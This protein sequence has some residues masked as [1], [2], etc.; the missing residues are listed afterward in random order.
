MALPY[1]SKYLMPH[2]GTPETGTSTLNRRQ[3]LKTLAL[4][5]IGS[6]LPT[7]ADGLNGTAINHISYQ[8]ADYKKTRDFYIDLLGF[9][10][11]DEDDKQ[12]Y[13]W[14]GDAII[15]AKNSPP[16]TA[17]RMDHFGFTLT[18]YDLTGVQGVLKQRGLAVMMSQ[19]DPHDPDG[20]YKTV[21]TRDP[22]NYTVQLCAK[23]AEVKPAPVPSH[24]PLKAAGIS[25]FSY[26]CSDYKKTVSFYADLFNLKI[27]NDDG[28]RAYVWLGDSFV[29]IRNNPNPAP[30]PVID[31]YAWTLADWNMD[32]VTTILKARNLPITPDPS[33][34]SLMTKDLNGYPL[35]LCSKDRYPKP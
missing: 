31:Y 26:L 10:V 27:S 7:R 24:A 25:H 11:S 14:A 18:P 21:F 5:A 9:Q 1:A 16:T 29:L 30:R 22:N 34:K 32:K 17:P 28:S 13:L 8:S 20:P 23:E 6:R 35:L 12:L 3:L 4:G 2:N 19:G 15:S 33:G